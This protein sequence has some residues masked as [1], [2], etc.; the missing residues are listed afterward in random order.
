MHFTEIIQK[1]R[2][3]RCFNNQRKIPRETLIEIIR[4]AQ[5][6]P[7]WANSQPWRVYMAIGNTLEGIKKD[8]HTA[9]SQG[10]RGHAEFSTMHR[11]AWAGTTRRN[12]ATWSGQ[13]QDHL[14]AEH[15]AEYSDSQRDL[16][17]A[18]A[19]VY[20]TIPSQSSLWSVFD[21]G[22][23]SQTLMYSAVDKGVGTMS[24]Y[25]TVKY[26][27]IVRK[28]MSIPATETVAMGIA[29]G[30]ADDYTIN[31]FVSEREPIESMLTVK[32]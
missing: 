7:S 27:E 22:A 31:E 2:S 15:A 26:P 23:F 28:W 20:L 16:F 19:I 12:M 17:H 13:I 4:E 10:M 29:L 6:T 5:Q 18:A 30:Y 25:E 1:R 3:I 9:S 11:E 24:A 21:L 32:D 14:G 8:H